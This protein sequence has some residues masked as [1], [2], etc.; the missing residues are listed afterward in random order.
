MLNQ[1]QSGLLFLFGL[2]IHG[3]KKLFEILALGVV[4]FFYLSEILAFAC[5]AVGIAIFLGPFYVADYL[6]SKGR[7]WWNQYL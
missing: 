1:I 2:L 4:W 5:A 3:I 7:D 6:I